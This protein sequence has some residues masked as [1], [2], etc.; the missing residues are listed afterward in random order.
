MGGSVTFT[1]LALKLAYGDDADV[2]KEKR[3]AAVQT[4]SGTGACRLMAE[5]QKK[6]EGR[7]YMYIP[8]PT[9]PK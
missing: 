5:Y 6:F 8:Y 9:W 2:L 7:V 1:D 3:V 4:L